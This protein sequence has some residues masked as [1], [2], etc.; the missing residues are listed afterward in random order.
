[1]MS[2]SKM[3]VLSMT[4]VIRSE[5]LSIP[6]SEARALLDLSLLR[7]IERRTIEK[8]RKGMA[9]NRSLMMVTCCPSVLFLYENSVRNAM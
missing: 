9:I 7:D 1:M 3:S 4:R 2:L 8:S 6:D 5:G